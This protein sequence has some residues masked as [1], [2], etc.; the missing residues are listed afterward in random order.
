VRPTSDRARENLFNVLVHGLGVAFEGIAVADL[1]AGSGALGL[2]ALSRGAARAV[3]VDS[4]PDALHAIKANAARLGEWRNV[5][6]L[7]LDAARLPPPPR[8][9]GGPFA[10]AFLDPPYDS[11]LALP[12][13]QGLAAR[14][15][16]KPGAL[17][18]V[19]VAALEPFEPP[20]GF[21]VADERTW[22]AARV[23]FVR[24]QGES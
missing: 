4:S 11:G 19:E 16:L 9:A 18:V 21:T 15:W 10:L 14:G 2:E 7:K 12:A 8:L 1:F 24:F 6:L 22:G 3:F 17:C 20:R 5:M 23:V 13:L